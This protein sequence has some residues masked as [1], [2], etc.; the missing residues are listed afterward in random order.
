MKSLAKDVWAKLPQFLKSSVKGLAGDVD[1]D[2]E[3]TQVPAEGAS[4]ASTSSV[5]VK[6]EESSTAVARKAVGKRQRVA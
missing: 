5:T 6:K 3:H 1:A 4:S 2:V